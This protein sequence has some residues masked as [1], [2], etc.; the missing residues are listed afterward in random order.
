MH[1]KEKAWLTDNL[2][3]RVRP[4]TRMGPSQA[5]S[6][7]P[8]L[9]RASIYSAID[10]RRHSAT[11]WRNPKLSLSLQTA[12]APLRLS[13]W[14]AAPPPLSL[15][16]FLS[17]RPETV[18]ADAMHCPY[19]PRTACGFWWDASSPNWGRDVV[20]RLIAIFLFEFR[21]A[22][23]SAFAFDRRFP[24]GICRCRGYWITICAWRR[25]D[26]TCSWS[27]VYL[28]F[29]KGFYYLEWSDCA[30]DFSCFRCTTDF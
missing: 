19:H 13:T 5:R 1:L 8:V 17:L 6:S 30:R 26:L 16:V 29:L 7:S 9:P 14:S 12:A 2:V 11:L 24:I 18:A 23:S 21:Y 10:L 4:F 28:L 27:R 20:A 25:V 3:D 15:F 22:V